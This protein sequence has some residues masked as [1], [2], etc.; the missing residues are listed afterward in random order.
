MKFMSS[1]KMNVLTLC[2]GAT[3]AMF[4]LNWE[5]HFT[6]MNET[7]MMAII[8]L[9]I[10]FVF[11]PKTWFHY[12]W[13]IFVAFCIIIPVCIELFKG[14]NNM[15]AVIFDSVLAL[16]LFGCYGYLIYKKRLTSK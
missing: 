10:P 3:L 12:I 7:V 6:F 4:Y 5:Y 2:I 14:T 13:G 15:V 8:I 11:F 9:F 1:P 16:I